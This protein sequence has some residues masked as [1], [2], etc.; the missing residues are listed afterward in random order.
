[1]CRFVKPEEPLAQTLESSRRAARSHRG[2]KRPNYNNLGDEEVEQPEVEEEDGEMSA[3]IGADYEMYEDSVSDQPP[4]DG[5]DAE[6]KE[7][8][9]YIAYVSSQ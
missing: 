2:A 3:G 4:S 5:E 9:G 1:M 7:R 6:G 8:H